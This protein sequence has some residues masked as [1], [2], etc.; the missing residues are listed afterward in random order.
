MNSYEVILWIVEKAGR[1][2]C[3]QFMMLKDKTKMYNHYMW[4]ARNQFRLVT[5]QLLFL[6]KNV[7]QNANQRLSANKLLSLGVRVCFKST[8]RDIYA[9]EFWGLGKNGE[10]IT[11]V[12]VE[13]TQKF[14]I[15]FYHSHPYT[16]QVQHKTSTYLTKN[17]RA[18]TLMLLLSIMPGFTSCGEGR[19]LYSRE[20]VCCV[21][22]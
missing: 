7:T 16:K 10:L 2:Y 18:S 5:L 22:Y 14:G 17:P 9:V 1:A 20:R 19:A 4:W 13:G 21:V 6:Y 11:N 15:L 3:M 12:G 8:D